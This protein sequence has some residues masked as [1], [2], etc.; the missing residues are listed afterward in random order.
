MAYLTEREREGKDRKEMRGDLERRRE[1]L[2]MRVNGAF[3]C[4]GSEKA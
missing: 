2:Q 1:K 3:H 4:V